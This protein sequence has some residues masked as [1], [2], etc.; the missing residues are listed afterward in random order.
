M[1]RIINITEAAAISE[2]DYIVIDYDI[3][4]GG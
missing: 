2:I 3:I 1:E 4:I